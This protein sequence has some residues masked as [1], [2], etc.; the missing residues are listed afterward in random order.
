MEPRR[1]RHRVYRV[2]RPRFGPPKGA[3]AERKQFM[4][5]LNR[6]REFQRAEVCAPGPSSS[7]AAKKAKRERS[8]PRSPAGQLVAAVGSTASRAK[9]AVNSVISSMVDRATKSWRPGVLEQ[10]HKQNTRRAYPSAVKSLS[11]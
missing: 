8:A 2:V 7:P 6:K 5:Q 1:G 11:L 9:A 3:G 4:Q 10:M